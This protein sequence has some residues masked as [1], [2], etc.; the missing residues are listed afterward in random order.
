MY[1]S[2]ASSVSFYAQKMRKQC[3]EQRGKYEGLRHLHQISQ[4]DTKC[5]GR[6][7]PM[8][9]NSNRAGCAPNDEAFV[10]KYVGRSH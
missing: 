6:A 1:A 3:M 5:V 8:D 9:R 2:Y 4:F 7:G 10:G